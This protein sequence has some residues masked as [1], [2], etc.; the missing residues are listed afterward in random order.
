MERKKILVIEDDENIRANITDL[1][2]EESYQVV[3]CNNGKIGI[4]KAKEFLPDLIISDVLMPLASGYEVLKELSKIK[5][6]RA[7]PFIFL[8]AKVERSDIRL[9]M[10]LGADDYLFKPFEADEL[11]RAI[12]SRLN[13]H[14]VIIEDHSTEKKSKAAK[15]KKYNSDERIVIT[16]NSRPIFLTINEIKYITSK[17][18]YTSVHLINGKSVLMRRPMKSWEDLLPGKLFLRIHR[19]TIINLNLIVKMEKWHGTSMVVYLKDVNEPFIMSNRYTSK[20]KSF[21]ILN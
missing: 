7:I 13:R 3:Q 4:E 14:E 2:D 20:I 16:V 11:L 6:T 10:E 17:S 9:G 18:Q 12:K 21:S 8:T 5:E 15:K 1:L 19:S